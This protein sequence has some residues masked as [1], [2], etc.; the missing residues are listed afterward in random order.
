MGNKVNIN[1]EKG[2]NT[3][4]MQFLQAVYTL[5]E[6]KTDEEFVEN[7]IKYFELC[8]KHDFKP[9]MES[10]ALSLST[11]RQTLW[12]WE[13]GVHPASQAVLD[14]IKKAKTI[15]QSGFVNCFMDG[16]VNPIAGIFLLKNNHGY[17]DVQDHVV[18]PG[19]ALGKVETVEQLSERAKM[20]LP[21]AD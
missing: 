12:N 5:P 18:T 19:G 9:S 10:Y 20:A 21:E 15:I 13:N 1:Q 2:Y 16:K 3:R 7:T 11:T 6:P 4:N 8:E 17:K 14:T